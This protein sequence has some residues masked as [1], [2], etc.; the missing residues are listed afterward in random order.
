MQTPVSMLKG[1][2]STTATAVLGLLVTLAI[3][4]AVKNQPPST[5]PQQL[6]R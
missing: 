4:A 1:T 2:G 5:S 3:L 6:Q